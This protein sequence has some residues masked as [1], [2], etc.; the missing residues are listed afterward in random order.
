MWSFFSIFKEKT[1]DVDDKVGIS[2]YILLFL[3]N[4][5]YFLSIAGVLFVNSNYINTFNVVVHSLL[6]LFLMYRFNPMNKTTTIREH[7]KAIIF[8][9]AFFLLLNL[10]IVEFIKS[11]YKVL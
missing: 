5:L 7:D 6:C 3:F 1:K 10:G 4:I 11:I 2:F 8:S 9:S